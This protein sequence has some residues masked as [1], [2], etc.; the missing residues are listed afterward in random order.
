M[1]HSIILAINV[2]AAPQRVFEILTT[3]EGQQA[4]WT[5]D[6]DVTADHARFGFAE[7]PVDLEVSVHTEANE[8]VQMQVLSGFPFWDGSTW[9]WALRPNGDSNDSTT[10][11]F[12]HYGFGEGI[13][14][15]DL[16]GTAQTWA[17]TLQHLANYIST[18]IGQP[19]FTAG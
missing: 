9:E 11:I 6:C 3:T 4:F 8:L 18:G 2:D 1:S 16:G 5:A 7:A 19:Y 17:M 14:E 10:V 12:R 13:A 15:N